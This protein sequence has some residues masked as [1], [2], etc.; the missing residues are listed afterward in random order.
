MIRSLSKIYI[1]I[2]PKHEFFSFSGI[3]KNQNLDEIG[4]SQPELHS[5]LV[6]YDK[7]INPLDT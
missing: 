6:L 7:Q 1:Y 3:I 2:L 4:W 5:G